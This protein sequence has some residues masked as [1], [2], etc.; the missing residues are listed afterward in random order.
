MTAAAPAW[1]VAGFGSLRIPAAVFEVLGYL[2]VVAA[3]SLAFLAGW[4]TVNGAVV[5]TVVLLSSLIVM[6]WVHLGQGRHPAFLFLCSLMLF[7][8]GRLIGYCL[9]AESDPMQVEIMTPAPFQVPREIAGLVLLALALSAICIYAPCRWMYRP[10]AP[11]SDVKVRKY[12]RYLYLLFFAT[13]PVQLFKNYR[14][15]EYVQQHGGYTF[16]YVNHAALASTVPFWVR[17]IPLITLPVFVAIFVFERRRSRLYVATVLY[18]ATASLILLLG[19][20]SGPFLLVATLWWV[21]RVKSKQKTRLV[22]LASFAVLVLLAGDL[23]Q[24]M[25]QG[26]A[27]AKYEPSLVRL[28]VSQGI[29]LNVSEVGFAYRD[30]FS[31]N[32][33]SYLLTEVQDAFVASD[34][35]NYRRGKGLSIDISVFLNRGQYRAGYGTAGSYIPEAYIGGGMIAVVLVSVALGLGLHAMYRFSGHPLLLFV[36]AM[37]LPDIILM[38]KGQLLDWVS[39]LLKNC[40]SFGLLWFGWKIYSLLVSIRHTPGTSP[41]SVAVA[42]GG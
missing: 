27:S 25:R 24:E 32:L 22:W 20:R 28:I 4:L 42:A 36:F 11:P 8:G 10:I 9:G 26:D 15:Y 41:E 34:V 2:A 17:A 1:P 18:F 13:L 38:P 35:A 5:L 12:L 21:A 6:S 14:Y 19:S 31:P 40:I 30:L 7:Q 23:I 16:I 39:I 3:G 37:S 33:G 29:S